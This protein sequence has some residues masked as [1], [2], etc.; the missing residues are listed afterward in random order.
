MKH[1]RTSTSSALA[2]LLGL[3]ATSAWGIEISNGIP[4]G[5][6]GSWTVDVETGGEATSGVLT[7]QPLNAHTLVTG[8]VVFSYLGY[9]DPGALGQGFAL[10]SES[11]P[12]QNPL[13]PN[14]V[15]SSGSFGGANDNTIDWEVVS[16]I[17]SGSPDMVNVY[18][19][20]AATGTLGLLRFY[21]YLDGDI[22]DDNFDDVLFVHGS[23][24]GGTL[25]V[26]TLDQPGVYGV[27]QSGALSPV[28]GLLN[29]QF[30]G[31]AA[32]AFSVGE[33]SELIVGRIAGNGQPVS[34]DGV[35]QD[36]QATADP[37]LGTVYGPDDITSVLAWDVDPN[38]SQA[39]IVTILRSIPAATA[40]GHCGDAVLDPGEACDLGPANGS[41]NCCTSDCKLAPAG[42][43]CRQSTNACDAAETCTGQS[44]EC[45]ADAFAPAGTVCRPATGACDQAEECTGTDASCPPDRLAPAGTVCRPATAACDQAGECTGTDGSCPADQPAPAGTVCRPAAGPCDLQEACDGLGTS[46]PPDVMKLDGDACDDGDPATGT[47]VCLDHVCVGV[48]TTVTVP[49]EITV[50]P[51][52]PPGQVK[53]PVHVEIPAGA[54]SSAATVLLQ[55]TVNCLDLQVSVRPK[56]CGAATS[57][58]SGYSFRVGSVF[59]PV[60]PRIRRSLGRTQA[61]SLTIGLPLTP[62]GQRLFA[63]L[64]PDEQ[65]RVLPVQVASKIRDRQHRTIEAVFP[66]L[67][68]RQR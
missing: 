25:E 20:A 58:T 51:G 55:G 47:S 27:G 2:G 8:N 26:L 42:S 68:S 38:A 64:K 46:C 33:S 63:K 41:G 61:R 32:D 5:T 17:A 62:L 39:I 11:S 35:I 40:I 10:S 14:I 49:P 30:A 50:P 44:A 4:Q 1:K 37:N 16:A 28:A 56:R 18:H 24:A 65:S 67:L 9:V 3:L 54:G 66:V 34:L 57:V 19:F 31:W 29:A 21:Q 60:T 52:K 43:V 13:D 45:P 22:G 48:T 12:M 23:S 36:L 15:T 6:L 53:I 59:L 7:A